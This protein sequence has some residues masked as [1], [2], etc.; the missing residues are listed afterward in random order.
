MTHG[1]PAQFGDVTWTGKHVGCD[2]LLRKLREIKPLV[3]I[4]GHIHEG[5]FFNDFLFFNQ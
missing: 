5:L 2:D 4:C 3:H 1:P